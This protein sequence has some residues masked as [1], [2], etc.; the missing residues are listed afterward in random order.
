MTNLN[1]LTH[2][3]FQAAVVPTRALINRRLPL[4]A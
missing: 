3:C 4:A 1:D 2:G